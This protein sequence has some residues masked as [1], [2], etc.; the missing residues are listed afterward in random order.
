MYIDDVEWDKKWEIGR[1]GAACLGLYTN[2][3]TVFATA[4]TDWAHGL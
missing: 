3:G 4:T 1:T 2:N